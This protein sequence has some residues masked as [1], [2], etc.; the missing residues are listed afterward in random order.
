MQGEVSASVDIEAPPGVIWE[1][2]CDPHRYPEI[3]DPTERMLH[4]PE[5]PMH[6]GYRYREYG[7]VGPFKD[8]S[9]W[10]VTEFEPERRQVHEGTDGS[11]TYHLVL[12]IEPTEQG[13]RYRQDLR[14]SAGGFMGVVSTVLWPLFMRR[15]AHQAMDRT[16]ENTKGA[17]EAAS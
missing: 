10:T 14:L 7:G 17:A 13:C 1:L 5:E 11:M 4:V 12:D 9:E 3:A 15:L 8:E 16:V 6:V 2:L